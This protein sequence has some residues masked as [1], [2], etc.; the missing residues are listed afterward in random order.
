MDSAFP[1]VLTLSGLFIRILSNPDSRLFPFIPGDIPVLTVNPD[2]LSQLTSNGS[3]TDI[4]VRID[5]SLCLVTAFKDAIIKDSNVG[6]LTMFL[7]GDKSPETEG[8]SSYDTSKIQKF[9]SC[10]EKKKK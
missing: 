8:V 3:F 10:K 2:R 1:I 7:L 5:C 9:I 6:F 4:F